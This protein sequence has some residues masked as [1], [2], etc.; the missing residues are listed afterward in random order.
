MKRIAGVQ[1]LKS[2]KLQKD[3]GARIEEI[4]SQ[5]APLRNRGRAG[6][7]KGG[8]G[9]TSPHARRAQLSSNFQTQRMKPAHQSKKDF[10]DLSS[11][12]PILPAPNLEEQK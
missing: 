9:K 12:P 4:T 11:Y 2:E 8:S 5:R 1:P 10:P 6:V 3:E 7:Q